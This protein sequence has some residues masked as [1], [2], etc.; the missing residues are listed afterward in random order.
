MGAPSKYRLFISAVSKELGAERREVAR[1]LMRKGLKVREQGYFTAGPANVAIGL[2][3]LARLLQDTNRLVEGEPLMR[4]H[5]EIFLAFTRSTGH[6]HPHLQAAFGNY[7]A[8]L[9][10][11]GRSEAEIEEIVEGL[12]SGARQ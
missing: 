3:N 7:H 11:M 6:E 10:E 8:L 2:N 1:V 12:M 5:L 9:T 4:R